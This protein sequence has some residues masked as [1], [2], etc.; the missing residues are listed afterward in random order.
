[1][2]CTLWQDFALAVYPYPHPPFDTRQKHLVTKAR[3]TNTKHPST[4]TP[5]HLQQ[6]LQSAKAARHGHKRVG[7]SS[8][9]RLSLMHVTHNLV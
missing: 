1:M 9:H 8:H 3:H 6:F 7:S 2:R 5:T 4:D